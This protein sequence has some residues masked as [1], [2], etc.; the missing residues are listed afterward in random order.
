M[1]KESIK[2]KAINWSAETDAATQKEVDAL[3]MDFNLGNEEPLVDAF[4]KNL[5]F[6]TGGLRGILGAGT[7]R[8]NRYTVGAAAQGLANYLTKTFPN[9]QTRIAIAHDSRNKS[10]EFAQLLADIFSGNGI[11]VFLFDSLRPTPLLSFAVRHLHCHSGVVIT[12]S[13]NPKEYNGFKAY[14]SDGAQ[15][16]S[17]HDKA[18]ILEVNAIQTNEQINFKRNDELVKLIGEQVDEA[19]LAKAVQLSII[20]DVI[21][22]Q[23]DLKI[24]YSPIHGTGVHLVPKLLQRFGF[25]NIHLL[26][27]QATPDG[28]FPT[29]VYPNPEEQEAMTL[30]LSKA[31]EIDADLVMATDPDADR[32]GIAV[33]NLDQEFELL[34]GNQTATLIIYYILEAW[35]SSGK[36]TGNEYITKT[37]VTS[38]L[39]DKIAADYEVKC[40]NTLTGFKYIAEVIGRLEGKETYLAGGEESYGYLIGDFV[41]DKDAVSACGIIAEIAAFAK[42][43]QISVFELLLQIY[44]KYGLYQ[45][46]LVSITKKGA[47]GAEEIKQMI[48]NFRESPPST[49]AGEPVVYVKDYTLGLLKNVQTGVV[50]NMEFPPSDVIQLETTEGTLVSARPSGTEPKI[51]FYISVNTSLT[52]I[53]SYQ[54]KMNDLKDKTSSILQQLNLE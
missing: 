30:A 27:S 36:L 47:A 37:I 44:V 5:E 32:V 14:W 48:Q 25:R 23:Q 41:R 38:Y 3:L 46:S 34:N 11:K 7:N 53:G 13:H 45:E 4:Y 33:K 12:A 49:L 22:A 35:K 15:L 39:L 51:K 1:N 28:N 29:V 2:Q 43:Q 17:P 52:N 19:Y 24:V 18:V 8:M 20:P 50:S 42:N 9:E 6:G 26:E 31:K 21:K 10:A 40:Y 16:V 54:S